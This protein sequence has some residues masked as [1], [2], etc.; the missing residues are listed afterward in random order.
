MSS[1][2]VFTLS[3]EGFPLDATATSVAWLDI[4]GGGGTVWGFN[5]CRLLDTGGLG[6]CNTSPNWTLLDC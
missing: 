4:P 5:F 3:D 1:V 2:G 6:T